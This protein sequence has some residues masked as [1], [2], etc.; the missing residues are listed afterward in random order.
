VSNSKATLK[1][2]FYQGMREYLVIT[3]YLWVIFALFDIYKAVLVKQYE[4]NLV[5]KSFAIINALALAKVALVAREL[6]FDQLLRPK[7]KPLIYPTLLNAAA[8]AVLLFCFKLLE[9]WAVGAY[10]GKT[11]SETVSEFI[12]GSW[13]GMLCISLIFFVMLIPFCAFAELGL[14]L[15]EGKLVRFFFRRHPQFEPDVLSSNEAAKR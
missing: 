8:F 4:I 2:R 3:A 6:K 14:A 12:G 9:E 5:A 13:Q 15:G 7:G 10:H 11:F 1:Q